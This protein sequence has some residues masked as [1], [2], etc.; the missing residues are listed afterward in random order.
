MSFK[1]VM[2]C[3]RACRARSLFQAQSW[4]VFISA[5]DGIV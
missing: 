1:V 3:Q 4:L 5:G 2:R